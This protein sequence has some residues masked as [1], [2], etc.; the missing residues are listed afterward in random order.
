MLIRAFDK[1]QVTFGFQ[2][3]DIEFWFWVIKQ[4]FE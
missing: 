3:E 4:K 1:A 2:G